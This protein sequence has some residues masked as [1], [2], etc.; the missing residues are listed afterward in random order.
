MPSRAERLGLASCSGA[1]VVTLRFLTS[2]FE[3]VPEPNN[4]QMRTSDDEG[5]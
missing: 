4:G 1:H 2:L 3:D 5:Q